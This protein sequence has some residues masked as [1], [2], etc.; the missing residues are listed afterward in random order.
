[1]KI[2]ILGYG[3]MGKA[4]E[5]IALQEGHQIIYKTS[6]S[7]DISALK[8]ADVAIEFTIAEAALENIKICLEENI[9]VVSGTTGWLKDFSKAEEVC[10]KYNGTF[11]YSSNFSIGVNLFFELNRKLADLMKN[12]TAYKLQM[13]EIHHTKKRD[14][15]SGTAISLAEDIIAKNPHKTGW[16]LSE[17]ASSPFTDQIIPISAK[18]YKDV[19]G[20]HI[21][22]YISDID[23]IEIKHTAFSREGFAKGALLAAEYISDKKGI[24]T[25]QEVL[26]NLI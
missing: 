19:K 13:E 22:E 23:S 8:K 2:A 24:F 7:I 20:T 5:K 26:Q 10:R 18:R 3:Q 21:I 1:M 15:P 25:M 6:D 9:P 14:A 11:L 12:Q 4:I 16:N 17:D